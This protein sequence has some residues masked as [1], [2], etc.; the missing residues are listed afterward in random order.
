[1]SCGAR[2]HSQRHDSHNTTNKHHNHPH[3]AIPYCNIPNNV[4][5]PPLADGL[6]ERTGPGLKLLQVQVVARHGSRTPYKVYNPTCWDGYV[7]LVVYGLV[8]R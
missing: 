7:R 3:P 8:V 5:I 1:M 2:R 6:V 4:E